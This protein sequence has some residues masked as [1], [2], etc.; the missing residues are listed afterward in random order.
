MGYSN[1]GDALSPILLE[2]LLGKSCVNTHAYQAQILG[3]GSI[4]E[5]FRN[6]GRLADL[7]SCS[8]PLHIFSSG[9]LHAEGVVNYTLPFYH[10]RFFVRKPI[11]HALRGKLTDA[12]MEKILGHPTRAVLGD[13]GLLANLLIDTSTIEKK[14]D[15]GVIGHWSDGF[16]PV[17]RQI[18]ETIPNS[19][20]I[21]IKSEPY[22][23][24]RQLAECKAVLSTAMHGLIASDAL[25]IP[26]AWAS[27]NN[28]L[29]T[30]YK[31]HD[32]YSV[33]D[34]AKTPINLLTERFDVNTLKKIYD[35]YDVTDA[36]VSRVQADLLQAAAGMKSQLEQESTHRCKALMIR[37]VA[38][39]LRQRARRYC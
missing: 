34:L 14:Y 28:P 30:E 12:R 29:V 21:D 19:I 2:K 17:L 6:R 1:F 27:F 35:S 26:N 22:A 39:K 33:F 37:R 5:Y 25:R 7:V 11:C 18:T 16:Q 36:A 10:K 31:F 9:F 13:A 23:F 8:R 38:Q 24:L 15:L 20:L 4:L 32:Y 3:I